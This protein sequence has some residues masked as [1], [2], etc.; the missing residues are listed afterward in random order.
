MALL[1]H[2]II[3]FLKNWHLFMTI[4][5][6][7]KNYDIIKTI[8]LLNWTRVK[9][10]KVLK[11]TEMFLS[12]HTWVCLNAYSNLLVTN[13]HTS[14]MA[15]MTNEKVDTYYLKWLVD[16][17]KYSIVTKSYVKRAQKLR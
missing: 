8:V 3:V 15:D 2:V 14:S 17:Y 4:R 5:Q 6:D 7:K 10:K 13:L 9:P 12:N 11:I 1:L 16:K